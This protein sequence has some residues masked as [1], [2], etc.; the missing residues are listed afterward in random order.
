MPDQTPESPAPQPEDPP[1]NAA[2]EAPCEEASW[3]AENLPPWKVLLH[4]DEEN[5]M[6]EVVESILMLTPLGKTEAV[7]RMLEAHHEGV[8]LLVTTHKERAELY[9]DQFQSRRLAVSIEPAEG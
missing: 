4:N 8:S 6:L 5:D 1:R 9:R 3:R 2:T 7:C